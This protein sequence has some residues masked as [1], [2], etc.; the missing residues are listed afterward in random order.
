MKT[1]VTKGTFYLTIASIIF[2]LSGYIINIWLGRFLGPNLYGTFGIIISLVTVINLTQTA[3]LPQAVSK[4]VAADTKKSEAIYKTGFLLQIISTVV[5]ALLFFLFSGVLARILKDP[6]LTSYLQLA[7][8]IFPLYGMFALLT[9]YYNGH[10]QFGKQ[11]LLHIAYSLIKIVMIIALTIFFGLYGVILGF[12]LSPLIALLVQFH[13]PKKKKTAY[14]Y[15]K[16]ILFSLPLIAVAIFANLLQSIDLFFVKALLHS[17]KNAGFYT[18][19]QNIAE[20]PFYALTAL[21]SVLFPS[22]SRHI[23]QNAHSKTKILIAKALRF[24][25][26]ILI[27]SVMLIATTSL[28]LLSFLF[29]SAYESGAQSLTILVIGSGFFTIF[30]LL[31]T[32]ISS[33]GS[34]IKSAVLTGLGV[35][36]NCILCVVL[37]PPFG[38][39]GAAFATTISSANMMFAAAI[40]VYQKFNILFSFKSVIKIVIATI[41]VTFLAKVVTIPVLYLPLL[42]IGLFILYLTLLFFMKE[43][44][45]EDI[46]VFK[47]LL[48]SKIANKKII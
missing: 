15:K 18:A 33:A 5:V 39:N 30:V 37:I 12:I 45:K 31:T 3:G 17:D 2:M 28:P 42:Y 11:A 34:P 44:N 1:N 35:I 26:L 25:L 13:L 40:I 32:I 19:N 16:L 47:I 9:G 27:P 6:G 20:I 4:Y 38:L 43:I 46:A 36:L 23:S 24:C 41:I 10:H 14:P 29:S 22:I 48:P 7:A 8:C 21:S